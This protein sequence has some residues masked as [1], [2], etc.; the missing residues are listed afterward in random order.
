MDR[1]PPGGGGGLLSLR[2]DGFDPLPVLQDTLPEAMAAW[3]ASS[4]GPESIWMRPN[5]ARVALW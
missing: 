4:L 2:M 5:F 1:W 3:L